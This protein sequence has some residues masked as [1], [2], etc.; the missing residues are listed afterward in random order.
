MHVKSQPQN[1]F[2]GGVGF[3]QVDFWS[4][5]LASGRVVSFFNACIF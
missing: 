4:S 3:G 2:F 1:D 5:C